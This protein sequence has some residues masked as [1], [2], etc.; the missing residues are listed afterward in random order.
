M[1]MKCHESKVQARQG[2]RE[3]FYLLVRNQRRMGGKC[4]CSHEISWAAGVT[5]QKYLSFIC[6][7]SFFLIYENKRTSIQQGKLWFIT[8]QVLCLWRGPSVQ[9]IMITL[10][11]PN[12]ITK[13]WSNG[14]T[15]M[16]SQTV[17]Q[18]AN[19]QTDQLNH[20]S[21]ISAHTDT[22]VMVGQS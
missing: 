6:I 22:I 15:N 10:Y 13:N 7:K 9:Y 14:A 21:H 19:N 18:V 20:H 8:T 16:S 5:M 1:K 4:H 17:I 3:L 11:S 12:I 2:E